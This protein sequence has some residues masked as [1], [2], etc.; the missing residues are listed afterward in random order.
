MKLPR[1]FVKPTALVFLVVALIS[2]HW[3]VNA[4]ERSDPALPRDFVAQ[5]DLDIQ[6]GVLLLAPLKK[7]V[8]VNA[9]WGPG[10]LAGVSATI[11]NL[12]KYLRAA[13]PGL[14]IIVGPEAG[15]V[16]I[17]ELKVRSAHIRHLLESVGHATGGVIQ[18]APFSGP[19]N[20]TIQSSKTTR[21][22]EPAVEVFNLGGY[23]RHLTEK[24]QKPQ[25][26]EQLV[27]KAL[28]DIKQI[29]AQTLD[30]LQ[31]G[32]VT[33]DETP[34]FQFHH[35]TSLLIV[36]GSSRAIEVSRKVVNALTGQPRPGTPELLDLP[37][38]GRP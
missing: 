1:S 32:K 25:E 4:Q 21:Q 34:E 17:K 31:K 19:G 2:F 8:D 35:G 14:N 7:R 10:S 23:I 18:T 20:W 22:I 26:Q 11:D 12:V 5:F 38:P 3:R 28:E 13:D 30:R 24:T 29:I 16:R 15:E 33:P 36:T 27:R 37:A 6:D 9:L